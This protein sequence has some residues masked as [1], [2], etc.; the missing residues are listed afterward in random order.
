M[1]DYTLIRS[2]R[3][4]I[5]LYIRADGIEVRAP[6]KTPKRDID[7]FVESKKKWIA[8]KLTK[9]TEQAEQRGNF[10]LSY[11]DFVMYRGGHYP[12]EAI[13]GNRIGFDKERFYMPRNL[14]PEQIK[15]A[16]ERIYRMLAKRYLTEKTFELAKKM[17]VNPIA[18]KTN[19][20]RT[21]WGSCSA[22]KSINF[23]WRLVMADDDIIDY[24][25]VHEL[26]HLTELNHSVRFWKIVESILPDYKDRKARLKELQN[27]LNRED[28]E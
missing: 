24:V 7:R 28:W 12:I 10:K 6:L 5:A 8:D 9:L 23:S 21:R 13:D 18:V 4:T 25:V 26:A 20:A 16:C 19:N 11:G 14:P 1:N 15:A 27:K 3:K 2:K 17:S 22:K